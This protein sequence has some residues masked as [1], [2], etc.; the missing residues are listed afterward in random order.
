MLSD[1]AETPETVGQVIA[2]IKT[3]VVA[4]GRHIDEDHYGAALAYRFGGPDDPGVAK[5]MEEYKARTGREA[6]D[7]FAMG[8][9]TLIADRIGE[10]V[11]VGA[12]KFILR[13]AARGDEDFYLQ[14]KRLIEEVL[15]IVA[16]RWP[17]PAK[18]LAAE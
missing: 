5:V 11:D 6:K 12:C 18:K 8:D 4:A 3:A 2:D 16:A 13:P 10:Y 7:H 15:P 1:L 17:K 9:A 14:T